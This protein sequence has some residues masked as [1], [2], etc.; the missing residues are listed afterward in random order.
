MVNKACLAWSLTAERIGNA[1]HCCRVKVW[2][3]V[4]NSL[5][6]GL[7]RLYLC[8]LALQVALLQLKVQQRSSRFSD[9]GLRPASTIWCLP[10]KSCVATATAAAAGLKPSHHT[11]RFSCCNTVRG[12]TKHTAY[13]STRVRCCKSACC[14]MRQP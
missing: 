4:V 7:R 3:C 14:V 9:T 5:A 13:Q 11:R 10:V 1:R 12:S 6:A 2:C 8:M